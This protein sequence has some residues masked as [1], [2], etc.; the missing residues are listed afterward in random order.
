MFPD[1][2]IY[3]LNNL[4]S[5]PGILKA[6]HRYFFRVSILSM[7]CT[8]R[9]G[10]PSPLHRLYWSAFANAGR[11]NLLMVSRIQGAV[12]LL[13]F[14]SHASHLFVLSQGRSLY[15]HIPAAHLPPGS[16]TAHI[17]HR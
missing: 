15:L 13:L 11:S 14:P 5:C 6:I 3:L 16:H 2:V 7:A 17:L 12:S 10:A 9:T 1:P 8:P 4:W